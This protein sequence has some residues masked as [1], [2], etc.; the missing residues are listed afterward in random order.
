M[1]RW[2]N[3][4][5]QVFVLLRMRV[6][7]PDRNSP[8][9]CTEMHV[10]GR[11]HRQASRQTVHCTTCSLAFYIVNIQQ[12]HRKMYFIQRFATRRLFTA[13]QQNIH[14]FSIS[15]NFDITGRTITALIERSRSKWSLP[16]KLPFWIG[17][18]R[19][20]RIILFSL[21]QIKD[22]EV[23]FVQKFRSWSFKTI[24]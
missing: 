11:Q 16:K 6:P 20:K 4:R 12:E 3:V 18:S 21:N 7:K 8:P 2:R 19:K 23:D 22:E 1:Q 24:L 14:P 13:F 9:Y 17:S 15:P 10:Q 5:Q